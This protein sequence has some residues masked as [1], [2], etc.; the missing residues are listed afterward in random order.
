MEKIQY[1]LIHMSIIYGQYNIPEI[2]LCRSGPVW[3]FVNKSARFCLLLIVGNFGRPRKKMSNSE[4]D[5]QRQQ[6]LPSLQE[7]NRTEERSRYMTIDLKVEEF[8]SSW[9]FRGSCRKLCTFNTRA[10]FWILGSSLIDNVSWIK[11][12]CHTDA[13][14]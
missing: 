1:Y 4:I 8:F 11:I 9:V 6:L 3:V 5:F 10:C 14:E 12:S 2:I 7:L 13:H